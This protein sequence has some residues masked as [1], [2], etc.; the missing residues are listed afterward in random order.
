MPES[1][2]APRLVPIDQ[3]NRLDPTAFAAALRPLFE[4][5]DPLAR[6]LLPCRPFTDYA[7]LLDRA[8]E[9]IGRLSEAEQVAIVNAHP[10]IGMPAEALR[11][12][13]EISYREQG[14]DREAASPEDLARRLVA[15]NQSYEA[16]FGFRFVVF[17]NRRPRA[18]VADIMEQRLHNTRSQ[19]LATALAEML[20]IARDR[21][22][23]LRGQ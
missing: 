2:S 17:V 9:V 8:A 4:A 19:E 18:V 11:A 21:L 14:Y 13:S 15:L 3:L 5:A 10:R 23:T 20:A 12:L 6:A 1:P 22:S 7:A 16:R